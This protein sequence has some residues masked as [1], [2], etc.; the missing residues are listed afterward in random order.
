[1][2]RRLWCCLP[3]TG[4]RRG[5][6][7]LLPVLLLPLLLVSACGGDEGARTLQLPGTTMGTSYNITLV[8]PPPELSRALSQAR[9]AADID[10][11]LTDIDA[12]MST[13]RQDSL[14]SRF[15][16][17]QQDD[18]FPV[19]ARLVALV[20]QSRVISELTA[21]AFDITVGGLVNLWGFGPALHAPRLPAEPQLQ[22]QRA[23]AG[24]AQLQSRAEPPAL[25][26]TRP[27][28]QL[29]L[30]AIAKGYAVDQVADYLDGVG[31]QNYL[32]EIGGELRLAG[33]NASGKPWRVAV[34]RPGGMAPEPM[35]V[36]ELSNAAV[37]T[38]GDYRNFYQIDGQRYSHAIDPAT[39]APVAHSLASVTV[40]DDNAARADALATGL[41]VLGPQ[42]GYR[43]AETEGLAVLFI[44]RDGDK[45]TPRWSPAF[46]YAINSAK[47]LQQQATETDHNE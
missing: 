23:A 8:A 36:L 47:G 40:I 14:L 7:R 10:A 45:L 19:S 22:A 33:H 2:S 46:M 43:I 5:T 26:K 1:M 31:V 21:G 27:Q 6:S 25:R 39:G 4:A 38:S 32:V 16:R 3:A 30:S 15:N 11:I 17:H 18:W 12:E 24:F 41:L 28:L 9:L 34:E 37:A 35:V 20:E 42:A 13:Y 29:D 44:R